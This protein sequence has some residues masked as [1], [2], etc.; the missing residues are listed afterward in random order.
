MS[1]NSKFMTGVLLGAAAGAAIAYFLTSEK[2]KEML[3]ELKS[4]LTSAGEKVKDTVQKFGSDIESETG[5]I[6]T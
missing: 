5:S 2:G 4:T 6:N 3:E 1:E